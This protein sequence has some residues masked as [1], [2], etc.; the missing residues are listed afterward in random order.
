MRVGSVETEAGMSCMRALGRLSLVCAAG[1]LG[2]EAARGGGD[3]I[4]I[5]EVTAFKDG[6]ALVL[7]SGVVATDGAGDVVL[8]GVPR[9]VLGTFW[10]DA[11]GQ[12]V[13][14]RSV[15]SERVEVEAR[16]GAESLV[17]L[18]RANVGETIAYRLRGDD[19]ERERR[20]RL[21]EVLESWEVEG[22]VPHWRSGVGRFTV[23]L[24]QGE[25]TFVG[26]VALVSG[27][28]GVAAV[29]LNE[30]VDVRFTGEAVAVSV[31]EARDRERM[32]L[33][34]AWDGA[35][36][37]T[38]DVSLMYVQ[39]GLRW[40]PSY[41]LE[42]L[43]DDR[44]RVALQATLVNELGDL[45]DAVVHLAVGVP[46]FAF[47]HTPDPMGLQEAF[48][49]LGFFFRD[50][51]ESGTSGMLSNAIMSQSA[52]MTEVRVEGGSGA[53]AGSPG[54]GAGERR[55]DLYVYRLEG[56]TLAKGGRMVVPVLEYEVEAERLYRLELIPSPPDRFR[57]R[58][59]RQNERELAALLE[60]PTARHVLRM[61]NENAGGV[62]M[63]TAPALVVR[64]GVAL[65]QG[66]L[67]YTPAG[68]TVDLE[69]GAAIDIEVEE[70]E[71]EL[72]RTEKAKR[73]N[74]SDYGRSDIRFELTLT[75]RKDHAVRVEVVKLAFGEAGEVSDGGES[76]RVS[77][78]RADRWSSAVVGRWWVWHPL[79]WYWY[80][81]NSATE[82]SWEVELEP[83]A[84]A[85]LSAEWH[86]FW[87]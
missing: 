64:D 2:V 18:V 62:P 68:G 80:R 84:S 17:D 57:Q 69:V 47:A 27:D 87:R 37:E 73:W 23:S 66:M 81:L 75:N 12:G 11:S 32:T 13:R 56:V 50:A 45:E 61:T 67:T 20:G 71:W 41:R 8:D 16:R 74:S 42:M 5:R 21:T 85:E 34:L 49:D 30:F 19:G 35:V 46:S 82:Y 1:L 26:G 53:G 55:E 31:V 7:R 15:R 6:H 59:N 79:P 24:S 43:S 4:P 65:A 76:L 51:D 86:Y 83:G 44:V 29:P 70:R 28:E 22:A 78:L 36:G 58:F 48:S 63:T 38:A 77:Q 52:R 60:R 10:A 3:G 14:L 39:R 33:D 54:F 72:S 25:R 9:P 40:I